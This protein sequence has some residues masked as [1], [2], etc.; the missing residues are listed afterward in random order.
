[1]CVKCRKNKGKLVVTDNKKGTG[2]THILS[3]LTQLRIKLT[4]IY[5]KSNDN[6]IIPT[7]NTIKE[8]ANNV[9]DGCPPEDDLNIIRIYIEN[10]YPKY[11]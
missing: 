1:M 8:W 5:H 2:C 10:E 7:I 3:E 6:S 11:F 4:E 9:N